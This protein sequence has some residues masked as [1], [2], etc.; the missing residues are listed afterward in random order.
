VGGYTV[1]EVAG[2]DFSIAVGDNDVVWQF[3]LFNADES[4]FDPH[5][6]SAVLLQLNRDD[7]TGTPFTLAGAT[8]AQAIRPDWAGRNMQ[9]ADFQGAGRGAGTYLVTAVTTMPGGEVIT[10]PANQ[11]KMRV[12]VGSAP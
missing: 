3:P 10:Y 11:R 4:P 9:A 12:L 1:D 5:G 2:Y 6:A 7:G 8:F